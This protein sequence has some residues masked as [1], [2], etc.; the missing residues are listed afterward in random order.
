MT[1]LG[2]TVFTVPTTRWVYSVLIFDA[3]Y[4][5]APRYRHDKEHDRPIMIEMP[6][7]RASYR[8]NG[9]DWEFSSVQVTR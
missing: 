2:H 1:Q 3:I 5:G 6:R 4:P 7:A 8:K 9:G